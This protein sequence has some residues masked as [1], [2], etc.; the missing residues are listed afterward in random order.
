M[1]QQ[2]SPDLQLTAMAIINPQPPIIDGASYDFL[3]V[4]LAMSTVPTSEGMRLSIAVTFTPYRDTDQGPVLLDDGKSTLV[5]GD[6][7]AAAKEDAALGTFLRVLEGAA[8][9]F[10]DQRV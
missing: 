5:Y 7:M 3:G 9:L 4:S 2:D 6:A 8:Q 1:E 10:V